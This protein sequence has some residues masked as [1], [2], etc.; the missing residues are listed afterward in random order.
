MRLKGSGLEKGWVQ[1]VPAILK[2]YNS[3]PH[4]TTS[5]S[6]NDAQKK[7]NELLVKFNIMNKAK[8]ARKY[9][10]LSLGDLVRKYKKPEQIR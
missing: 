7:G 1:L 8:F 2:R 10:P 9:P 4:S 6:P 5:L 3:L